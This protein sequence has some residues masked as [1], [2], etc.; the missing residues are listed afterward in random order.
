MMSPVD[1]EGSVEGGSGEGGAGSVEGSVV[2]MQASRLK[3]MASAKTI[4]VFDGCV[5]IWQT[6]A[7]NGIAVEPLT[8]LRIRNLSSPGHPLQPDKN[9]RQERVAQAGHLAGRLRNRV[10]RWLPRHR[11]NGGQGID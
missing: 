11:D 6:L 8:Q 4:M 10:G 1:W 9:Q 3:N 5:F 7:F 2:P